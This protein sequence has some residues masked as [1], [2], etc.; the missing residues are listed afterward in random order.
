[1]L[2]YKETIKIKRQKQMLTKLTVK[3]SAKIGFTNPKSETK[4]FQKPSETPRNKG[5]IAGWVVSHFSMPHLH[6]SKISNFKN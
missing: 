4:N 1:M 2:I 3:K 5:K 6:F